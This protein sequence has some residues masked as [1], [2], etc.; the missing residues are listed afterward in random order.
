MAFPLTPR[1]PWQIKYGL[2]STS[3]PPSA[4]SPPPVYHPP[5]PLPSAVQP[6]PK[7]KPKPKARLQPAAPPSKALNKPGSKPAPRPKHAGKRPRKATPDPP[8]SARP[9]RNTAY[10]F[11]RPSPLSTDST[12][13]R[14]PSKALQTGPAPRLFSETN[15]FPPSLPPHKPTH[16]PRLTSNIFFAPPV[17]LPPDHP[18]PEPPRPRPESLLPFIPAPTNNV[19]EL[20]FLVA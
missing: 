20:R 1:N 18:D 10:H 12:T 4:P 17:P 9:P 19:T 15:P 16:H 11:V 5:D 3:S 13:Q 14:P 6:K 8:P 7:P 2:F